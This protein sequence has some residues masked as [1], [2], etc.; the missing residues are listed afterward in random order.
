LV[1]ADAEKATLRTIA[2]EST[3]FVVADIVVSPDFIG[4]G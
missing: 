2:T 4:F 3:S 1:A